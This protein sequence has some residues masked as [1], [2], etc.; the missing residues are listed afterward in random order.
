M[1]RISIPWGTI[2]C[3]R[4]VTNAKFVP[5]TEWIRIGDIQKIRVT[6]EMAAAQTNAALEFAFQVATDEGQAPTS[7]ISKGGAL[8]ADGM[9]YTNVET[10]TGD[11]GNNV[12]I[13]FGFKAY[14][15]S[16]DNTL[17]CASA[18]GSIEYMSC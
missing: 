7:F 5:R 4:D 6:W 16:E 18:G 1:R 11:I 10:I 2:H 17:V 3:F 13:R 9:K 14:N 15:S 8:T 12:W